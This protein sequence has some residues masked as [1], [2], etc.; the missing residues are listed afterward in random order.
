[1]KT[2]VHAML[3][4]IVGLG[5]LAMPVRGQGSS[6]TRQ[7]VLDEM[8]REK[9]RHLEPYTV[10]NWERRTLWYEGNPVHAKLLDKGYHGIR[11]AIGGMP[12]GS[13]FVVGLGYLA[14]RYSEVTRFTL[15]GRY[16]TKSFKRASAEFDFPGPEAQ[17]PFVMNVRGQYHDYPDLRFYGLGPNTSD[18]DKT[19]YLMEGRELK[20]SIDSNF[21][22]RQ[23]YIPPLVEA[24][25]RASILNTSTGGGDSDP[26][27]EEEFIGVPGFDDRGEWGIYGAF[28]Q[29]N[30]LDSTYPQ[31]G[32]VV[33]FD[34]DYYDDRIEEG[35]VW[36]FT[37]WV[38]E[39]KGYLPLGPRSRRLA[40]RVR[41]SYSLP[42]ED[43]AVPFYLMETIGGARTVRGY[44]EYRYRDTRNI[45]LN[46]EYRWEIWPH[47]D[48]F[49]FFDAGKVFDNTDDLDLAET[50]GGTGM[51]FH[52]PGAGVVDFSFAYSSETWAIHIGGG[53]NF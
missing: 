11:G 7:G 38:A 49:V 17:W 16:S 41:S 27:L 33:R 15:D 5:L 51:R 8:R 34:F 37:R 26:S 24:G 32:V 25:F 14:G 53:P 3:A 43:A 31:A 44:K 6:N 10:S 29:L 13:G 30:L 4:A 39:A 45:V 42:D 36:E 1:M 50:G 52:A 21:R 40:V 9:S 20:L 47:A 12:S 19:F 23:G 28:A 18:D 48:W 46:A 35:Q 22:K 2:A